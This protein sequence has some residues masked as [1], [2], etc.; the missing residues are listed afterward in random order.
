VVRDRIERREDDESDA[1]FEVHRLYRETFDPLARDHVTV[2]NSDGLE[3]TR[4]QV[5]ELFPESA[6]DPPGAEL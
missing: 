3:V 6:G 2:D 5:A 4:R 1:D